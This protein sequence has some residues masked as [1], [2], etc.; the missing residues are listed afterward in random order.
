ML[1][2]LY[3]HGVKCFAP[4]FSNNFKDIFNTCCNCKPHNLLQVALVVSLNNL[5]FAHRFLV[6]WKVVQ[7][8]PNVFNT[9]CGVSLPFV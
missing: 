4:Q 1:D 5:D 2:I 9:V 6:S 3:K 7:L 8:R